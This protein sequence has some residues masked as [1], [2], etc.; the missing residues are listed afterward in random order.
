MFSLFTEKEE[1]LLINPTISDAIALQ[2]ITS[3]RKEKEIDNNF[4]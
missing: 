2:H 1:S 3:I 4:H